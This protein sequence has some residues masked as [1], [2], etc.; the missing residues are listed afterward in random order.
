[1]AQVMGPSVRCLGIFHGTGGLTFTGMSERSLS[2]ARC[3]CREYRYGLPLSL[4]TWP[5]SLNVRPKGANSGQTVRQV[6]QDTPT[7]RAKF[8]TARTSSGNMRPAG[9]VT[10]AI[11]LFIH[12]RGSPFLS[13]SPRP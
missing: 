13:A 2:Q 3:G 12:V 9:A 7:W 11:S 4:S 6:W 10:P 5:S 1:M 8:E